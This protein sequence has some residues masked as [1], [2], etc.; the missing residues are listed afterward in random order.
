MFDCKR[1]LDEIHDNNIVGIL[2]RP[3]AGKT[4]ISAG[5]V[6]ENEKR[7]QKNRGKY[8]DRIYCTD[9]TIKGTI[10]IKYKEFG[11]WNIKDNSLILLEECGLGFDN[12]NKN[13]LP[14]IV[15]RTMALIG[16]HK[17]CIVWSSQR[18]DIEINLR[19]R[20]HV[21]YLVDKLSSRFSLVKT[22]SYAVDVDNELGEIV[23]KYH[24]PEGLAEVFRAIKQ[25]DYKYLYRPQYYKQFDS[26]N[27]DYIYPALDPADRM[28]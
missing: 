12:R 6:I 8:F 16:H 18:A 15:K 23:N 7:K 22:I 19:E 5:L 11:T 1:L 9:E 26:F 3:R 27:D 14:E 24:K 25:H 20:T 21:I 17:S 10:P 4:T 28:K 2:G 13:Q